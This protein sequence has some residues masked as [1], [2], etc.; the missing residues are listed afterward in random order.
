MSV[1]PNAISRGPQ[2]LAEDGVGTCGPTEERQV[3]L[4][5]R[6]LQCARQLGANNSGAGTKGWLRRR[7]DRRPSQLGHH[8]F[9]PRATVSTGPSE[10]GEVRF[11][12]RERGDL[13]KR[14][15]NPYA[16]G[17]PPSLRITGPRIQ[18]GA[19][20]KGFPVSYPVGPRR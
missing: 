13:S 8:C 6:T 11:H 4:L 9:V 15:G 12:Q 2:R 20:G 16:V 5:E 18:R 14:D 3:T 7:R 19:D 17:T 10:A 1:A